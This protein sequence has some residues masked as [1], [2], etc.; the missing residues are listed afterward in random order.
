MLFSKI[1][2]TKAN[3]ICRFK[4][5]PEKSTDYLQYLRQEKYCA[6][7]CFFGCR[8]NVLFCLSAKLLHLI[9]TTVRLWNVLIVIWSWWFFS[10]KIQYVIFEN[11]PQMVR[12]KLGINRC[13]SIESESKCVTKMQ[14]KIALNRRL[15][16]DSYAASKF[17]IWIKQ[18]FI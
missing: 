4:L 15:K 12:I 18:R 7:S 6:W 10:Y 3:F 8:F 13:E 16:K 2:I 17:C 11:Y 1:I 5:N 9:W 14:A